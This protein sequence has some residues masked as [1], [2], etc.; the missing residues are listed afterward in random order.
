M[1]D[2]GDQ[3]DIRASA[4]PVGG[5]TVRV[6]LDRTRYSA[7]DSSRRSRPTPQARN[8]ER[9]DRMVRLLRSLIAF[10]S[11]GVAASSNGAPALDLAAYR[12]KVVVID[13]WASWCQPCRQSFPW[14][15][16]L[17]AKYGPQGLVVIGV[18][19][20]REQQDAARFLAD[21]PAQFQILYDA[22]GALAAKYDV[23]GMPSSY[24]F[25]RDGRLITKHI[26]FRNAAREERE[27]ELQKLLSTTHQ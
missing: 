12:G 8:I 9:L 1:F 11:L 3:P 23:P 6:S 19:V 2:L 21:Y 16:A 15:N 4:Y 5:G 10:I 14:L 26:G 22:E 18:N 20:D 17:Q 27:A 7:I 25:G 24:V 13:F